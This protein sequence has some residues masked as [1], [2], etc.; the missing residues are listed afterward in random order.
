MYRKMLRIPRAAHPSNKSIIDGLKIDTRLL[1]K[2][3]RNRVKYFGHVV[4][5]QIQSKE[6]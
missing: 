1:T 2:I 5:P 4:R 3:N 6:Q